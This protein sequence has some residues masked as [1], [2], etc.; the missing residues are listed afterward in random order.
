M[1]ELKIFWIVTLA[2]ATGIGYL[3]GKYFGKQIGIAQERRAQD[4]LR[5]VQK[6]CGIL[7]LVLVLSCLASDAF[8][9]SRCGR[10][11]NQC[12]FVAQQYVA[13]IVHHAVAVTPVAAIQQPSVLVV[14]NQYPSA[15]VYGG[16]GLPLTAQQG[17]TQ[18]GYT[19]SQT[20]QF[21]QIDPA[22][23]IHQSVSFAHGA[24]SLFKA[25]M[26]G[27]NA[28]M[29]KALHL[30]H[31]Q[32]Q[33]LAQ[34]AA[35]KIVLDAAGVHPQAQQF[36]QQQSGYKITFD[37]NGQPKVESLQAEQLQGFRAKYPQ[38]DPNGYP[39]GAQKPPCD[40]VQPPAPVNSLLSQKCN[41]CH[42]SASAQGGNFAFDFTRQLDCPTALKM[43]RLIKTNDTS[44][45]M[46]K[47][48]QLTPQ[49]KEQLEKELLEMSK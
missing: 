34:A 45:S 38:F 16:Q 18:F 42:L 23:L 29:D 39:G 4:A 22:A 10:F 37:A 30:Q 20:Q 14:N 21:Q 8:G 47:N 5:D 44:R 1:S 46:P 24:Q 13:P 35:A 33:P 27:S 49:E 43:I 32:N 19:L 26:D 25:G 36:R 12:A 11:G 17:S 28:L 40:P 48:E 6:H 31:L 7:S 9:C 2:C 3:V 15:N 41:R